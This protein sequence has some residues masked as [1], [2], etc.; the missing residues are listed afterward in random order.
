MR[1]KIRTKLILSF[2]TPI[3]PLV[4]VV[5][6]VSVY[7]LNNLY[8]EAQRLDAISQERMKVADL[9]LSLDQALM[10][11]ND[12]IITGDRKYIEDFK[13]I[14][15]D[16]E[17]GLKEVEEILPLN[18]E[19]G[20]DDEVKEEREILKDVK[21]S[22]Q[23]IKEISLKIYAIPAPVG[24]KDAMRLMEEMD[25][26]WGYPAIERLKRWR[27]IDLKEYKN[28]LEKHHRSW[29]GLW[30]VIFI[31]SLSFPI[32]SLLYILYYSHQFV[33][34]IE[35]LKNGA[36][37]IADGNLDEHID[38]RTGDEIEELSVLFNSM[39]DNLKVSYTSL[40]DRVMERTRELK[41]SEE[42]YRIL[43]NAVPDIIF[44]L[45]KEGIF[46][47]F[48]GEEGELYVTSDKF[49]GKKISDVMPQEVAQQATHFMEQAIKTGAIQTFEYKLPLP[50]GI[51]DYEARLEATED[52]FLILIRN[53]TER[54]KAEEKLREQLNEL[55]RFQKVAV[56]RE[57]RIKELQERVKELEGR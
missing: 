23:N 42:R 36:K 5:I 21:G 28:V 11:V 34:S 54:K 29:M 39:A 2:F 56:K 57:F 47:D 16:L 35:A 48:K 49:L 6:I 8:N 20:F 51:Q 13:A 53:I 14:S 31:V 41:E 24:N 50:E 43:L 37:T 26:K 7:I 25:Y 17:S 1:L 22:W 44:R 15:I 33:K 40:E 27:E 55:V 9:R 32:L 38:L 52:G 30:T 18:V 4:A 3:I 45:S 12:Y 10:P 19:I 46:L